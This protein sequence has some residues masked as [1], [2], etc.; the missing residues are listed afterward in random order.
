MTSTPKPN[1]DYDRR[2]GRPLVN[3]RDALDALTD[4]QLE[5]ELTIAAGDPRHRAERLDAV[6]LELTRRRQRPPV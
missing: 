4:P 1:I 6:L 3:G 5:A 2:T